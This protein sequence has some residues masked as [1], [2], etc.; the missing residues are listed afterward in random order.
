M[1]HPCL[2][3][4]KDVNCDMVSATHRG[5]AQIRLYDWR[6]NASPRAW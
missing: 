5:M 3:E 1:A 6:S 4:A 2:M